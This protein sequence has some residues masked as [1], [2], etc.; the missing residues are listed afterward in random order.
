MRPFLLIALVLVLTAFSTVLVVH[1][2]AQEVRGRVSVPFVVGL[3]AF[4]LVLYSLLV[5]LIP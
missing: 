4:N 5:L 1:L 2:R 3:V